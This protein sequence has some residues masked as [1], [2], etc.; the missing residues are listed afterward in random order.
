LPERFLGIVLQFG[1]QR[2]QMTFEDSQGLRWP[3]ASC[4]SL[5]L[6]IVVVLSRR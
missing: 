5:D 4:K 3:P 6:L 1:H 2:L